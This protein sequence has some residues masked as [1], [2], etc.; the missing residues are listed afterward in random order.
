[1]EG[2][3][4]RGK[5]DPPVASTPTVADLMAPLKQMAVALERTAKANEDL[6]V[7]AKEERDT[8]ESIL[9]PAMCPHC[10]M[11]NPSI[12]NEG[13]DGSM[14]DFVLVAKCGNCQNT[15]YAVPQGWLAFA[16]PEDARATIE[17]RGK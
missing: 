13:G 10:G 17:G 15:I 1:M 12:R 16:T 7:L 11:F 3:E 5:T 14:S 8:G 4:K 6:I 9:G 2:S